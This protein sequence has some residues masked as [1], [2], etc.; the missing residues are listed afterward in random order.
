VF[1]LVYTPYVM[2]LAISAAISVVLLV[3]AWRN[4]A[5]P[6][7]PWFAATL[8][9]LLWWT[10]GYMFELMAVGTS[11]KVAWADIEYVGT[12]LLPLF[13]LIVILF[14]TGRQGLPRRWVAPLAAVAAG[15]IVMVF[16]NPGGLFRGHATVV[17]SGSLRA[18]SPDYGPLWRYVGLP[19]LYVLSLVA[20]FLLVRGMLHTRRVHARQYAALLVATLIPLVAGAAYALGLSPWP[21]YNPAMAVISVS[22]VLMAYALFRYRLF[23]IAPLARDAVID[24]LADGLVV[25]DLEG[26]LRDFNAA[27]C[28]AFPALDDDAVGRPVEEVLAIHPA[29]LD[30]LRR[31]AEA[32]G[33]GLEVVPGGIVRA[34]VSVMMPSD[35]ARRDFNLSLTPVRSRGRRV[36]GHALLLHDV[37]E[38][39][40]LLERL[41]ELQA[42]DELTGLLSAREWRTEAA[43]EL[44]RARRYGYGVGMLLLDLDQLGH[45][46]ETC[47]TAA[48]DAILQAVAGACR[49][50]QRPFDIVGRVG[51]DE[52]A[53]LMPHNTPEEAAAA[54][55]RLRDAV[56]ALE[57]PVEDERIRV[58]GCLGVATADDVGGLDLASLFNQVEEALRTAKLSGRGSVA[59][60]SVA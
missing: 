54:A 56:G 39:V 47:G 59:S 19:Y 26:R 53:V 27:A 28:G 42:R 25:V 11:A 52:I 29:M 51:N 1:H 10:V 22:G 46:N 8:L 31:E 20:V 14:F 35:G 12:T 23:D 5:E 55:A 2:P 38:S 49:K 34:D 6:V 48:G 43:V 45:V 3:V 58:S 24:E 16:A 4:W 50:T 44:L 57:V 15:V 37:T 7:A 33:S 17:A 9:A 21:E 60:A 32:A 40:R 30:G 13:W 41:S 36:V 18:L